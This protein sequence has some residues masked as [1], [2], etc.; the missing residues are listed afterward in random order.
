MCLLLPLLFTLAVRAQEFFA[1]T[2]TIPLTNQTAYP[3]DKITLICEADGTPPPVTVINRKEQGH[4]G[5]KFPDREDYSREAVRVVKT[6]ASVSVDDEGWYVCI[7]LNQRSIAVSEAYLRVEDRC[8]ETCSPPRVCLKGDCTCATDCLSSSYAPVCGSDCRNYYN[9]CMMKEHACENG[10][11][12]S[13]VHE[14]FCNG[15]I[16]ELS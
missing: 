6:F 12:L 7:A 2:I 9:T 8:L 15:K 14:G 1:P 3:G 11:E 10:L 5:L 13:V 16:K 4:M